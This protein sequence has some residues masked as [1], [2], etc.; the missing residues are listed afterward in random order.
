VYST[1]AM[2]RV[3]QYVYNSRNWQIATIQPDGSVLLTEYDG[4]GRIVGQTDALGNTTQYV[5]D[6][7]G[8][9]VEEIQPDPDS[10]GP[11]TVTTLK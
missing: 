5:Y 3:T 7:L 8:R 11:S 10:S 1:D 6:K 2:G 9:Q 4:G